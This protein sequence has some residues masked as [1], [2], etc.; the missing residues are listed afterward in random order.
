MRTPSCGLLPGGIPP[1]HPGLAPLGAFV[2]VI[3][4]SIVLS[5]LM[6]RTPSYG[7]LP[8]GYPPD[9]LGSLRS[10]PSYVD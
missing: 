10:I 5:Q 4:G 1:D 3:K 8:G 7:L 6:M 9:P 2:C